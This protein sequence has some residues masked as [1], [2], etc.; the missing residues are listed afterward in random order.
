MSV[1]TIVDAVYR[2]S[3]M[4]AGLFLVLIAAL[5]IAQIVARLFG[6]IVPSAENFSS[7]CMVASSF[8]ALAYTLRING[9]VRVSL[10][11]SRFSGRFR[12]LAE[13]PALAI[14]SG[15][16]GYFLV[17]AID[18][19][20]QSYVLDDYDTGLIPT[21]L[22]IPQMAIVIGLA[23]LFVALLDDLLQV[24]RGELASYQQAKDAGAGGVFGEDQAPDGDKTADTL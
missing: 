17:Y 19:A 7:Y 9:H 16:C 15:L 4:L 6:V 13:I 3:A 20:W 2:S 8:L 12:I 21:P 24:L 5:V 18:L 23:L 11:T 1:R 14:S 22:W 10:L